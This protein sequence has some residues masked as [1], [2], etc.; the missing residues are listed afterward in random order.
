MRIDDSARTPD[1]P[2]LDPPDLPPSGGQAALDQVAWLK[3]QSAQF[4]CL[5]LGCV[6]WLMLLALAAALYVLAR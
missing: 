1:E 6:P 3:R 5:G 4:S 2:L